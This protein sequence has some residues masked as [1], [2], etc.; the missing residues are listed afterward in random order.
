MIKKLT[1]NELRSLNSIV[2]K[3]ELLSID[4][5]TSIIKKLHHKRKLRTNTISKNIISNIEKMRDKK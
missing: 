1:L 2:L 3:S 5:K 4:I